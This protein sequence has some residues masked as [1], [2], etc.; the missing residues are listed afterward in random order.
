M[1]SWQPKLGQEPWARV[2]SKWEENTVVLN[3]AVSSAGS[4]FLPWLSSDAINF[5]VP[6][7]WGQCCLPYLEKLL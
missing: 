4:G 7:I 2:R 1:K 6:W 5:L 3:P